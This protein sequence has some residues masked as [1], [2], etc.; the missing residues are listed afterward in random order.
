MTAVQAFED[1]DLNHDGRLS[2]DEFKRWY[3]SSTPDSAAQQESFG[4]QLT[5]DDV[6]SI[7]GFNNYS[8]DELFEHFAL[9]A[10][11][12]G[13]IN[14]QRFINAA[15]QVAPDNVDNVYRRDSSNAVRDL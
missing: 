9:V 1:A 2:Y 7:T 6:R 8:S 3:L 11:D 13:L 12:E 15:A 5:T 14:K 4:S 10:D